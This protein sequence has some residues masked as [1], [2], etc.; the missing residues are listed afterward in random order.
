MLASWADERVETFSRGMKQRLHLA[1]GLVGNPRLVIL[2]EPTTGMDPVGARTFRGLVRDLR[3]E[4]R[5]VLLTTH[6]MAEAE[7]VCDR[8]SLIDAG[9]LLRTEDPRTVGAG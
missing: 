6:D 9:R 7:S 3:A 4:R 8:V 5:T 1:R 2:D